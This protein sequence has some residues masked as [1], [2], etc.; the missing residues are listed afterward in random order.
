MRYYCALVGMLLVSLSVSSCRV[1]WG[2]ETVTSLV[3]INWDAGPSTTVY[4]AVGELGHYKYQRFEGSVVITSP[5]SGRWG[6][7]ERVEGV[8]SQPVTQPIRAESIGLRQS[9]K[10][11]TLT[12]DPVPSL[13]LV[14]VRGTWADF[15]AGRNVVLGLSERAWSI[16]TAAIQ[17]GFL[18]QMDVL[19]GRI[20][21]K[22]GW[23]SSISEADVPDILVHEKPLIRVSRGQ[24]MIFFERLEISSAFD[25][26]EHR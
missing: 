15:V 18:D 11:M 25:V 9:G 5:G 21:S 14:F 17:D 10:G 19:M 26:S 4:S 1:S 23:R 16:W 6:L 13:E 7:A 20:G 2:Y 8:S 3:S 24:V 22:T 12:F